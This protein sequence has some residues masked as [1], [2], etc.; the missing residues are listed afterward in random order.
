ML[1]AVNIENKVND[2][3]RQK[4]KNKNVGKIFSDNL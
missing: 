1:R 4:E 3:F 2:N